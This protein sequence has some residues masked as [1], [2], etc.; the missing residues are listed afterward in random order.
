MKKAT[1]LLWLSLVLLLPTLVKSQQREKYNFNP[2]WKLVVGDPEGAASVGFDDNSW[3]A[4][5]LPHAW[6]EDEAFAQRIDSL[7]TG[8]AW[9][10]KHFKIPAKDRGKKVFVEFEGYRMGGDIYLNGEMIGRHENGVMAFGLDL[11]DK[12]KWDAENV[13]A[14]RIDNA[15]NYK[16]KATGSGFQWNDR[17]FNAN[18]GGITKN[19]W[20][21]VT[22]KLYQTFPL[23]SF[24]KTTGTYIYAKDINIPKKTA[25]VFV[26]AQFKNE[27]NTAQRTV[28]KAIVRDR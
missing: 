21:H 28:L 19:V 20:L 11:T 10:R 14:V 5:T 23:Y 13:I 22:D 27:Y 15:W 7:S 2:G 17:N 24:F 3:K 12:I 25:T 6:N 18:Y 4:I 1:L 26:E 8:I 9:Y 16:E